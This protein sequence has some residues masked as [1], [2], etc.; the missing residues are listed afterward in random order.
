MKAEGVCRGERIEFRVLELCS[1]GEWGD[2]QVLPTAK[3]SPALE[4][5]LNELLGNKCKAVLA[6]DALLVEV[7]DV[8]VTLYKD[9][10]GVLEG[11]R[12]DSPEAAWKVYRRVMG[13]EV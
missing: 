10:R 5:I 12:P 8:S 11:V 4:A 9:G 13:R 6:E 2:Y 3:I 1:Y 7:D